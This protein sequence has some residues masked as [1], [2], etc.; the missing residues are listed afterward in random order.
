VSRTT[1]RHRKPDQRPSGRPSVA[2]QR[3][4]SGPSVARRHRKSSSIVSVLQNKPARA[5]AVAVAGSAL[6]VAAWPTASHWIAELPHASGVGQA[7][8]FGLARAGAHRSPAHQPAPT[9]D[10]YAS[11]QPAA[12]LGEFVSQEPEIVSVAVAS[13]P[14]RHRKPSQTGQPAP[15]TSGYLNPLRAV[16]GL[17][18]ERV[19]QGVDFAGTGPVYAIG[20]AVVTDAMGGNSGWPGGGWVSYQLT[21]GPDAGLVVYVAED[22]TPTVQAGQHVSSATVIANMYNGGDGIETGWAAAQ[23]SLTAESQMPEAGGIG[24]GGPFPTMVGLS[25]DGL[26]QSLGVPASPGAG[27]S[28]YGTL[29]A[30]YP[31]A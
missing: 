26:L 7:D 24:A 6:L 23:T 16:S 1:A 8:A 12:T 22:V 2:P 13:R 20:D 9:A 19:D 15:A 14:G 3:S 10:V 30:G 17:V 11:G 29:P 21:D 18:P 27:T 4:S 28:G 31:A 5:A 25:F